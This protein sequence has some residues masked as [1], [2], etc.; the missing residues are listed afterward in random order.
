VRYLG[1]LE[2]KY[3]NVVKLQSY[4]TFDEVCVLAHKVETQMK[5][6]PLKRETPKPLPKG[7]PFH[8]GRFPYPTKPRGRPLFVKKIRL[9]KKAKPHQIGLTHPQML[10]RDALGVKALAILLPNVLIR[11]LSLWLNGSLVRRKKKK[12]TEY[13]VYWRKRRNKRR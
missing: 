11:E 8:K 2:P 10:P 3:A 7:T 5:L 12:K 1:D 6:Q 9:H 4:T 13:Y